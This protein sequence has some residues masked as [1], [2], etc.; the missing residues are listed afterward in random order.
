MSNLQA[1][2]ATNI[3]APDASV[4]PKQ[5]NANQYFNNFYSGN[6]SIGPDK[7]DAINAFFEKYT[8]NAV[9]GRQLSAA[10]IYTAKA[11]NIDPMAIVTEF[12][13][14]T[15]NQISNYLAAFLNI[16]RVPT[17][18]LGTRET[19][20]KSNSAISRSIRP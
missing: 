12:Q 20:A 13:Q 10:V 7:N 15:S 3:K 6:F 2:T 18:T 8:G 16:N 4:S 19:A 1:S 17:S 11:Q 5:P 14:L 9:A